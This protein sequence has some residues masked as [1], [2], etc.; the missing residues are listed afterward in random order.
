MVL[1]DSYIS[2]L[3]RS[4][5]FTLVLLTFAC[6]HADTSSADPAIQSA[7]KAEK[8]KADANNQINILVLPL[9]NDLQTTMEGMN[10]VFTTAQNLR[11]GTEETTKGQPA[12]NDDIDVVY[13]K[14][15]VVLG[16]LFVLQG[17]LEA[18]ITRMKDGT[19]EQK[20][21]TEMMEKLRIDL[22][23]YKTSLK[24]YSEMLGT[25]EAE[26]PKAKK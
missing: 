12:S 23:S 21:A 26:A 18:I 7:Q 8:D 24:N 22:E 25:T 15:G 13:R 5:S 17:S 2:G 19:L 11:T 16:S 10:G 9:R 1:R 20:Q 14:S 3:L 4:V 6:Q